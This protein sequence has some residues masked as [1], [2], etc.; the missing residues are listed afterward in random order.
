MFPQ[1]SCNLFSSGFAGS[2]RV[3]DPQSIF[4]IEKLSP[5]QP[6]RDN[7]L[8]HEEGQH[9][10]EYAKLEN[11]SLQLPMKLLSI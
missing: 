11:L 1:W 5:Q 2:Y 3:C 8:N 7:V 4:L 9:N 6:P 10:Y